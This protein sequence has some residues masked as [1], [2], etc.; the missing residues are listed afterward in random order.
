[1]K[2]FVIDAALAL[3]A[4]VVAGVFGRQFR[5]VYKVG[6]ENVIKSFSYGIG[7]GLGFFLLLLLVG[8]FVPKDRALYATFFLILPILAVSFAA[9]S[10]LI[11]GL[12]G[13]DGGRHRFAAIL[14]V[15][16]AVLAGDAFFPF[17]GKTITRAVLLYGLGAS[18]LALQY[19]MEDE[20][21]PGGAEPPAGAPEPRRRH[22][23][24]DLGPLPRGNDEDAG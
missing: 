2:N 7:A 17:I 8:I 19:P 10:A 9:G 22:L 4:L 5:H 23:A 12:A 13:L 6:R 20:V 15:G 24:G 11:A 1:M 14:L 18:V 16:A 21:L 3:L